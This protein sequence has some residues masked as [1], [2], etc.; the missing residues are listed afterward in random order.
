MGYYQLDEKDYFTVSDP[1][2]TALLYS[3]DDYGKTN[4]IASEKDSEYTV[5]GFDEYS[6][7]NIK[8]SDKNG[9]IYYTQYSMLVPNSDLADAKFVD[10]RWARATALDTENEQIRQQVYNQI[11]GY[12]STAALKD[13]DGDEI[14]GPLSNDIKPAIDNATMT[15]VKAYGI[16]PQWT[17][18]VDPRVYA[19]TLPYK[20]GSYEVTCA[21]GRRFFEVTISRPTIVEIAPGRVYYPTEG[22]GTKEDYAK[23][24]DKFNNL[25]IANISE[26]TSDEK[27][28]FFTIKPCYNDSPDGKIHGYISYV[29]VLMRVFSAFLS[30]N[31]ESTA[32]E[33]NYYSCKSTTSTDVI[34]SSSNRQFSERLVPV[35]GGPYRD[36]TWHLYDGEGTYASFDI[37]S[38]TRNFGA[39]NEKGEYGLMLSLNNGMTEDGF[40]YIRFFGLNGTKSSD[41]FDTQLDDTQMAGLVNG[42]SDGVRDAAFFL[43]GIIGKNFANELDD[44]EEELKKYANDDGK[45]GILSALLDSTAEVIRGGKVMFPK[46]ISDCDYGKSMSIECVFSSIYGDPESIYLNGYSG[47]AHILAMAL[48][49]QVRSSIEIYTYPYIVKAFCK[50]VFSCPMGVI[51]GLSVEYAGEAGDMWSNDSVPSEIKVSFQITPLLS[52]LALTSE[53]DSSGWLLRNNGLQEYIATIAGSDLR[54]DKTALA[55]ELSSIMLQGLPAKMVTNL[56]QREW[57]KL[58]MSTGGRF[59][60]NIYNYFQDG[61]TIGDAFDDLLNGGAKRALNNTKDKLNDF[62]RKLDN[63][64]SI[65]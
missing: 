33:I 58:Y 4:P 21:L 65:M 20:Q 16:P 28:S 13:E 60:V 34:M 8:V 38:V 6:F 37:G 62:K 35:F 61:N 39:A 2:G 19:F 25:S 11:Y 7:D 63:E 52:K 1:T 53:N 10:I 50:G 45:G 31:V 24:L 30:R 14:V 9:N 40:T 42:V 26:I 51:N 15:V 43:S 3:T 17:K 59:L 55:I 49:H 48:P 36:F 27:A 22:L 54:S 47:L 41:S 32:H 57:D 23:A 46:I 18:Y 64:I 12:T 56:F 5:W 29:S 44:A